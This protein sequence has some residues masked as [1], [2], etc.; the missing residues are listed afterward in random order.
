MAQGPG[1]PALTLPQFIFQTPDG[2]AFAN[3]D[4]PHDRGWLFAFFDPTCDHCQRAARKMDDSAGLYTIM[5][6]YI[7]STAPIPQLQ[8]FVRKYAPHLKARL[9]SDPDAR[10]MLKFHPQRYPA[11][12]VYAPDQHLLEYEDNPDT[13]YRIHNNLAAWRRMHPHG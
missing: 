10:N 3:A 5:N 11:I 9:L 7:V 2:H 4:L 13:I 1:G 12:F 6:V 8:A